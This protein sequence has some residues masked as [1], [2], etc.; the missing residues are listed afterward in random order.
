MSDE[1]VTVATYRFAPKAEMARVLL[2]QEGIAAFVADAELVTTD[3]LLGGAVGHVKL[4]VPASQVDAANALLERHR[5]A[6][7]EAQATSESTEEAVRCLSCGAAMTDA[8]EKCPACGWTY[9]SGE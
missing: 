1:P 5:Q 9:A 2:E 7:D 8:D 4:Q 3:W 6:L